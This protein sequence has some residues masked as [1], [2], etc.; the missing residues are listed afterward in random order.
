M[1]PR[2]VSVVCLILSLMLLSMTGVQEPGAYPDLPGSGKIDLSRTKDLPVR[3]ALVTEEWVQ[4]LSAPN[5]MATVL[6]TLTPGQSVAWLGEADKWHR[7]LMASGRL[8]YV[9]RETLLPLGPTVVLHPSEKGNAM[10]DLQMA[11]A[12]RYLDVPYRWGGASISGTDCSGFVLQVMDN[13]G[14]NLPRTAREQA[15]VG[16]PVEVSE[17]APGD[18]LYFASRRGGEIDHTGI[19]IGDGKFI[20]ASGRHRRVSIDHLADYRHMLVN[21]RRSPL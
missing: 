5:P 8:G 20:H 14:V 17:L 18:R 9:P 13:F 4:V 7:V 16:F 15:L 10:T 12:K 2:I 11:E 21:A 19:Y 1:L 6:C 3:F